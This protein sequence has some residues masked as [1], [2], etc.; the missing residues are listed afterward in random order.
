MLQEEQVLRTRAASANRVI[1]HA[2]LDCFYCQVEIVRLGLDPKQPMAV[3]QW[4]GVI[5]VNYP[6]RKAVRE[7]GV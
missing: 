1:I 4:G 7:P 3:Q 6:A 5:A 2:D